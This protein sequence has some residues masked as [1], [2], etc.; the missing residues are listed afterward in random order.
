MKQTAR[1]LFTVRH[2]TK[3]VTCQNILQHT[4]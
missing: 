2:T 4:T 3:Q 1:V